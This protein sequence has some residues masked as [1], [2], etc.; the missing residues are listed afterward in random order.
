MLR[1]VVQSASLVGECYYH[2]ETLGDCSDIVKDEPCPAEQPATP[3]A[4]TIHQPP[5]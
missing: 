4:G 3:A 1:M 5:T 2:R